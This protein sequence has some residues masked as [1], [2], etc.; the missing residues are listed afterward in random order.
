M[1]VKSFRARVSASRDSKA[2]RSERFTLELRGRVEEDVTALEQG[3][4]PPPWCFSFRVHGIFR[5]GA[6]GNDYMR[7]FS[8]RIPGGGT[9]HYFETRYH[10]FSVFFSFAHSSCSSLTRPFW[11]FSRPYFPR[12]NQPGEQAAATYG[13]LTV[14]SL[15]VFIALTA[16]G[17]ATRA[18]ET[19]SAAF[20]TMHSDSPTDCPGGIKRHRRSPPG[21]NLPVDWRQMRCFRFTLCSSFPPQRPAGELVSHLTLGSFHWPPCL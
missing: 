3:R 16:L 13:S 21:R 2:P 6:T 1:L 9:V 10:P 11:R 5:M 14:I 19:S 12:G 17:A 7:S 8:T 20:A 4:A 18:L 15:A